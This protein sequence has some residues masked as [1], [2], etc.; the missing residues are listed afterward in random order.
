MLEESQK[1]RAPSEQFV[2]RF[3]RVYTPVVMALALLVFL[4]TP[5]ALGWTWRHALY[6]SM[7]VLLI[8]CPCAL[9]I[10]TP[11]AIAAALASAA[12]HGVLIKGGAYLEAAGKLRAFAFDKTGVVTTGNPMVVAVEPFEG[13][14]VNQV[15]RAAAAIELGSE[16]PLGQAVRRYADTLNVETARS[17]G[18]RAYPGRGASADIGG[19]AHWIG[20][21]RMLAELGL[22]K[23]ASKAGEWEAS[24]HTVVFVGTSD[25]V[26]GL[27]S[28]TDEIRPGMA[29]SIRG[30]RALGI[31]ETTI[32]TGDNRTTATAAARAVGADGAFGELLPDDKVSR[33]RDMK[34]K[35]GAVAMAGDGINDAQAMTESTLG[36]A[37]GNRS[38][39]V[40]MEAADVIVM[41]EDPERLPFLVSHSQRSLRV[42]QQ[43]VALALG[44]K[45]IFLALAFLGAATLWMAIAADMG[46]TLLVTFNGLRLLNNRKQN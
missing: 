17:T 33:V 21:E 31:V 44:S 4:L 25:R 38:T 24:G 11:V 30:L 10:S 36:I 20:S 7:V 5:F 39:D 13:S 19:V 14:T 45:A 41:S 42:I 9:V 35:H 46:A 1:R 3:A 27:I 37:I 6:Q 22:S 12:R 40:A 23:P 29:E 28:L 18:F 8:S 15:L 16:H 26:S 2:E 43:N 32:L 34:V